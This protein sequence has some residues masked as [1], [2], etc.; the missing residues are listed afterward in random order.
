MEDGSHHN[1]D[2]AI[3]SVAGSDS[4]GASSGFE[5]TVKLRARIEK[6]AHWKINPA[7]IDFRRGVP[8]SHGGHAT[9]SEGFIDIRG[10]DMRDLKKRALDKNLDRQAINDLLK[11]RGREEVKRPEQGGTVA[12]KSVAGRRGRIPWGKM[13][14]AVKKMRVAEDSDFE[15]VLGLAIREAEFLV[16]VTH[17]N[18][19]E[20]EGFV[21]DISEGTIWLVF[22]WS[23]D[24]NLKGFIASHK[25]EIPEKISLI[26]DVAQG[27]A[28]LHSRDPPICHGDLKSLNVLVCRDETDW[29]EEKVY[30]RITDFGSARR[31]S[32]HDPNINAQA[33]SQ[34][35]PV[36][37][38]SV[39]FNPSTKAI[40]LTG[41]KY[42]LRW[43]AP[44]L[45]LEDQMSLWSDIWAL[46]WIAYE[47]MTES[48]PFEEVNSDFDVVVRVVE[49]KL[50]SLRDDANLALIHELCS[51]MEMCWKVQPTERP[52]AE[53]CQ[54]A[55]EDMPMLAPEMQEDSKRINS[56]CLLEVGQM[57]QSTGEYARAFD[58][59]VEVCEISKEEFPNIT[60]QALSNLAKL[61]RHQKNYNETIALHDMI[62]EIDW[63]N[64]GDIY[65]EDIVFNA[66]FDL[67][68]LHRLRKEHNKAIGPHSEGWETH[69]EDTMAKVL[70]FDAQKHERENRHD[71]AVR[72]YNAAL[73]IST[74]LG[75]RKGR[76]DALWGLADA[77][78]YRS[79]YREAIPLYSEAFKI[80]IDL[81]NEESQADHHGILVDAHRHRGGY[82]K[83]IAQYSEA[84]KIS[85]DLGNRKG[86][87]DALWGLTDVHRLQGEFDK[88]SP[89]YTEALK[90][91]TDFA[92]RASQADVLWDLADEHR[93]RREYGEA[94]PL[95]TEAL[96]IRT[97]L[98]NTEG[99]FDA[100]WGI[101]DAHRHRGE[102]REVIPLYTEALEI[103]TKLGQR[104]RKADAL[105]ALADAHRH[106]GEYKQAIPL[107][108]EVLKIRA[109][110][111]NR[112]R[113]ANALWGLADVHRLRREYDKAIPL[114]SEA[115]EIRTDLCDGEGKADVLWGL[116]DAHRLRR[117]Y[118]KAIPLYSD[119]LKLSSD[120]GN[121]EGRADALWG[122]ADAHR[123]RGE[124]EAAIPL[125]TEALEIHTKPGDR[126]RR[127]DALWGLADAHRHRGEYG[128]AIPLYTEALEIRTELGHRKRKADVLWGLADA[129]R[130]RGE[131]DE[132]IPLYSET[133][134]IRTDLGDQKGQAEALRGLADTRRRRNMGG[135]A[136]ALKDVAN[137]R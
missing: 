125:Y 38:P 42:T 10:V 14:V 115:L 70:R 1:T 127:A 34:A 66:F 52:T 135:R 36:Y 63:P 27:L 67:A 54:S 19:V 121:T 11:L 111:G 9:V 128:E 64:E 101:A 15:R 105:W 51:L 113:R 76:A 77:H 86:I 16:G 56:N 116:A 48:L 37:S 40:T 45:L 13:S 89:F 35:P 98:G 104:K 79:E 12:R 4:S 39:T 91:A 131:W 120:L 85:T 90:I 65:E 129:H 100:L 69:K 108:T 134:E 71:Q 32:Q 93:H 55:I 72:L 21:E 60:F 6:L 8:E 94:I 78:R 25:W 122:L 103:C 59:F 109:K 24:G 84:L 58:L 46:G 82:E 88:S 119:A 3:P 97:D 68:E 61:A 110:L 75:H 26:N 81:G 23:Y 126:K 41:N 53:S 95:Y 80:S 17:R 124:Y 118:D 87:A 62:W 107:Y 5:P 83:A 31:L 30:A 20:L 123:R 136:D 114:Y 117:E 92:N 49:G 28:Y 106:R 18:I 44:E 96:E 33:E 133:L 102:Y 47:V 29:E 112:K 73:K 57:Y 137:A 132:A 43:A 7:S 50:P 99:R 130:H 2:D 74:E 22:P